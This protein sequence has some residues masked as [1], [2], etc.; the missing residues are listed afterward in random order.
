VTDLKLSRTVRIS[1]KAKREKKCH[2]LVASVNSWLRI[3][4]LHTLFSL[5][6]ML[7]S[8]NY[9]R[10]SKFSE[11]IA[12]LNHPVLFSP[13]GYDKVIT[14]QNPSFIFFKVRCFRTSTLTNHPKVI[15]TE[16]ALSSN[17]TPRFSRLAKNEA[18]HVLFDYLHCTRSFSFMDAEH[19][20]K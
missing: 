14:K 15:V 13:V 16:S 9:N 8:R 19:I 17:F 20:S 2:Y 18:Q 5:L 12:K 11:M 10:V 1:S 7:I 4:S 6:V 3:F